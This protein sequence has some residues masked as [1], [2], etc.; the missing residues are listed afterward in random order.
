[1][2]PAGLNNISQ[3]ITSLRTVEG[4]TTAEVELVNAAGRKVGTAQFIYTLVDGSLKIETVV[5]PDAEA[6][7]SLARVGLTFAVAEDCGNVEYF[8]RGNFETYTDRNQAGRIGIWKTT[9][10]GMFHPYVRPQACGNR[11][12]VR[13]G[14]ITDATGCGLYFTSERPFQFA[15]LPYTDAVLDAAKHLDD[16]VPCGCVTVH[17][18]AEQA[19]VGTATCGPGVQPK[20]QVRV[21]E[22]RFVFRLTPISPQPLAANITAD[23]FFEQSLLFP[24]GA[25][26]DY[27][28]ML[29][30]RLV[31]SPRQLAWQRRELTAFLHFGINTFTDREWGNGREDPALF[32]PSELDA[33]QWVRTLKEC[34]FG[35]V[36]LTAKHHDGFCLW[37]TATTRHS[38]ASSPW[39]EGRGDVV[40]EV[41]EAC[42]E[43]GMKFGVYLSPWDRNASC[44]GDSPAY[45]RMF[46]DQL[47]ELL[48]NY[49]E[50]AEVWFDGACAEGPNGRRQEYD[51]SAFLATIRR[52]QPDAVTAIMGN[53]VR[54][55]GN[56]RG[57]GR[58][59][60]WSAT[61][62]TPESYP[63]YK[64]NNA[65]TGAYAKAP[66]LGSR[67]VLAK[68]RE[69]FWYPSEVDVSVRPGWF[70]HKHESPKSLAQLVDIYYTSAGRNSVL[71]LNVPPDR[72]GLL[73]DRDVKRLYEL[74]AYLDA[75]FGSD[76]VAKG[77]Q[78]RTADAGKTLKYKLLRDSEVDV[79]M[80]CE[81]IEQGQRIESFAV[82]AL[83]SEGWRE[84]AHG[85]TVGN[86]RLLRFE[87]VKA[88]A[89]RVRV[90]SSRGRAQLS[91]V[92]A[93]RSAD[94]VQA[95][96]MA[97]TDAKVLK[98][99]KYAAATDGALEIRLPAPQRITGFVYTPA[100]GRDADGLPFRY[101]VTS[102]GRAVA[103]GEFGN[104]MHNPGP[105]RVT[106]PEPLPDGEL[107]IEAQTADGTP[108]VVSAAEL[109]LLAE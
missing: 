71:L 91:R 18:D 23:G 77:A 47:T 27:K 36:I 11:T 48:T 76:R 62:L 66:D 97:V 43:Y 39:R 107:R 38:V 99:D 35:M 88:R 15:A 31:P 13:W 79:V 7:K 45:N 92:G 70:W 75:T 67:E 16:L 100:A 104:I 26:A 52:L 20:Y 44:Y 6:V 68:A 29:A 101:R 80:L 106:L 65:L 34:G 14:R 55:V 8:G 24:E 95:A 83:T 33:R 78:L 17:L 1:M 57:M 63:R 86:K 102:H 25:S 84:V 82:E 87:P 53:D 96:A 94:L 73:D 19:G 72:R 49:G 59:T 32:N 58:E 9:A 10:A 28:A 2:Q 98:V 41:S 12:D 93:F 4:S 108:A 85:T 54:W 46:V 51:W 90:E 21:G 60:E 3:R 22:H 40:R 105:Q 64:E 89:L 42:A 103:T 50:V 109:V 5:N 56:E 74:R 61:V 30:G 37:P 81:Y 69:L